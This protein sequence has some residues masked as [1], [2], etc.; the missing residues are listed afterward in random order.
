MLRQGKQETKL[1]L[2]HETWPLKDSALKTWGIN[3]NFV[4][5]QVCPRNYCTHGPA[6]RFSREQTE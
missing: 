4:S 1:S 5:L 3:L 6:L 2:T